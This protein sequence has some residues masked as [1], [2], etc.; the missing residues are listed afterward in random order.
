MIFVV[1]AEYKH[2]ITDRLL[3]DLFRYISGD[4]AKL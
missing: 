4:G 3:Y 1:K 2:T